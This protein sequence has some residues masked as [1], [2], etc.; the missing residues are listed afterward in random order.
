M[1]ENQNQNQ[2]VQNNGSTWHT[3]GAFVWDL[4]KILVIALII[5]VPFR[6]YV[7]EPFVVSVLPCFRTSITMTI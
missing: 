5:I 7:A 2:E 3:I 1:R 6:M 4:V